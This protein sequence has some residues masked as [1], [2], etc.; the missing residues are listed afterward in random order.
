MIIGVWQ[1]G[2]AL[3]EKQTFEEPKVLLAMRQ[4]ST[5]WEHLFPKEQHRIMRLL[6]ERVQLRA[7]G[8]DII[9]RDDSWH[10]FQRELER[11]PFVDEQREATTA[12]INEME[13]A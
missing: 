3:K 6:I 10:Q 7:G 4:I 9:W 1:A 13:I 5:V 8:L 12:G 2:M 11:H